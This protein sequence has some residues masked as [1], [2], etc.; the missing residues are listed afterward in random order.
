MQVP[1][2]GQP[3]GELPDRREVGAPAVLRQMG[4]RFEPPFDRATV[5]PVERP[6]PVVLGERA[7][8][9]GHDAHRLRVVA[10]LTV[11]RLDELMDEGGECFRHSLMVG[12]RRDRR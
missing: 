10:T 11:P 1:F 7:E 2:D 8:P 5:E 9:W 6:P 4:L 3:A 12:K